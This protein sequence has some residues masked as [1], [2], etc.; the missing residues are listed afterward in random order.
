MR[1]MFPRNS[2]GDDGVPERTMHEFDPPPRT[3]IGPADEAVE[4]VLNGLDAEE[5]VVVTDDGVRQAGVVDA[6]V[7]RLDPQPTVDDDVAPNP[8]VGTVR[9]VAA[10]VR[11]TDAVVAVGGG[12]VM[13]AAKVAC[14]LP[15]FG[16]EFET[17][18]ASAPEERPPAPETA[19]PLVLVPTTAGTGTETGHWAVVSDHAADRKLSV[20]HPALRA[21]AAV[22]DPGLTESLPPY[23]TAATGFDVLA[24]AIESLT[25][26]GASAFT[27]PHSRE[28]Y[29][30]ATEHLQRAFEN[31]SD[32]E[33]RKRMLEASYLAGLAMN[34]AGLGAVHGIS[35]AIGGLY[36]TPHGHTNALLLPHVVRA[37]A[38]RSEAARTGYA[39]L[40]GDA[41]D[42]GERLAERIEDLLTST[43]LDG[44]LPGAPADWDWDAVAERAVG[45]VNTETNPAS[46]SRRD[47]VAVCERAFE[48]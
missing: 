33:A 48:N 7:D 23:L 28:A 42:P 13:D 9:S 32:A 35:H 20:G 8:S 31:G 29:R 44:D 19:I 34:N 43:D 5:V 26:T 12:S 21:E 3:R 2:V 10:T 25:A 18:R 30:L 45:N 36:D 22:L 46:L 14:A 37:N 15:A 4:R 17:L 40:V 11:G 1:H 27:R 39:R 6:V 38:R 16:G 41:D 24:H 47:V